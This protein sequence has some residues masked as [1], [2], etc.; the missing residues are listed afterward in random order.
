M[1]P[2]KLQAGLFG[3]FPFIATFSILPYAVT[4]RAVVVLPPAV[5]YCYM[6][7]FC[8]IQKD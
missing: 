6:L 2:I 5:T 7:L 4:F 1:G 8:V 3:I